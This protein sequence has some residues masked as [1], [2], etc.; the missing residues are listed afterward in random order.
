MASPLK[1]R[2]VGTNKHETSE[3]VTIPIY[4]PGK[5][6]EEN[7]DVL[8]CLRRELDLVE[9]LRAKMLIGNDIIAPEE[10]TVDIANGKAQIG[11]CKVTINIDARQR[12]DQ[13]IRRNVHAKSATD[14][15]P[16]TEMMLP[17]KSIPLP[18]D[19]DFLF[20][21]ECHASLTMYCHLIDAGNVGIMVRN[22]TDSP[23]Q[24]PR[25][26]K[27]GNVSEI[28]FDNYFHVDMPE[29]RDLAKLPPSS[30]I[31]TES[32][33]RVISHS[34]QSFETQLPN[35]MMVYGD[36]H[37][38]KAF[39]D[40]VDE[41]PTL[42]K[43]EGSV[44]VPMDEWMKIPLRSDWES[45]VKARTNAKVYPLGLKDREVV[46][47]VLDELYDKER[48]EWT[49]QATPFSYPVF[50]VWKT[51]ANGDKKGRAVVDIRG[52]NELIIPDAY[53]VPL[54]SE[55]IA[56]L[57]GCNIISVL[58]ASSFFYQWRVHPDY[59]HM[60]TIVTHR[61]QETVNVPIIG[62]MNSVAYVQRRID[63]IL[64]PIREFARAYVDD[65]GCGSKSLSAHLAD[66]RKLFR[67]LVEFNV[68]ISPKKAFLGY[69]N[70]S[71]LGQKVNSFGLVT[72]EDKL[73]AI[74]Q[75]TYPDTLGA[76]EHYL[77]LTGYLRQYVNYY[78]QLAEPLQNLKTRLLKESPSSKGNPR[79][80]YSSKTKLGEPTPLEFESFRAL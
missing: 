79:K 80:V 16:R 71:L 35:G 14:I 50:V 1:V 53:P 22:D 4:L 5:T 58:D 77:G 6:T 44:D 11:S 30:S 70:V 47:K 55:V 9:D 10:I 28:G 31:P 43:D 21:P 66:L 15:H 37:A 26:F 27:L 73:R 69:P 76:L 65:I 29:A 74:S 2:G 25:K 13:F 41:F 7:K 32:I 36:E 12:G 17:T 34:S 54:Q 57:Q 38:T 20:E 23:I 51:L 40:L 63:Q 24:I 48:V 46:N 64:R 19:R 67:L 59:R 3:Y 39:S 78:A 72:A 61:G 56:S 52:L 8:A 75:L 62:C 45:R 60:L 49:T 18:P 33:P 68:S 42:W